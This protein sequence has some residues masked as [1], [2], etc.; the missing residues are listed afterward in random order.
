MNFRNK[1]RWSII[2]TYCIGWT[3]AFIFLSIIRG[4]GATEDG[5]FDFDF[6]TSVLYS[7]IMGPIFGAISGYAQIYINERI[8][9][10]AS[11]RKL[12][13]IRISSSLLF[14]LI[15]ILISY[16]IIPPLFSVDISFIDFVVDDGSLPIYI[17]VFCVDAFMGAFSQINL[18]LG[19]SNL[20]KI[21]RGKFYTP[22]EEHRI[23]MF[24]DL[25]SST[26]HAERLG[27]LKYSMLIRDCFN[28][29][30]VVIENEAEVYQ[31]VGDEAILTWKLEDGLRN[32]NCINAFFNFKNRL[33]KKQQ[34]YKENYSLV[35]FFK[36][37]LNDGVVAATEVGKYKKEIAYHGDT[38]NTAARIQGKCNEFQQ[39]LLIS[40]SLK[41]KL[42]L[43]NNHVEL[44][45]DI[46]LRGKQ[47]NVQIYSVSNSILS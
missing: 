47:A 41:T 10:R 20:W 33:L 16:I 45:G 15:L 23:F 36:A 26:E 17:Y 13:L 21:F 43:K 2:L 22:H 31:Y 32:Q 27:H 14:I 18:M 44:L 46:M 40:E 37:G 4:I 30:G 28:D 11:A 34:Y 19:G 3:L 12:F 39:E 6:K 38:L 1:H 9:K 8:Y 5:A 24:L 42:D 25:Q 35:P 29:L 7:V